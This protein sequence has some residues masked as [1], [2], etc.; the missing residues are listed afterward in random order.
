MNR[1]DL[2]INHKL[3]LNQNEPLKYLNLFSLNL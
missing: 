1:T 3:T 2:E